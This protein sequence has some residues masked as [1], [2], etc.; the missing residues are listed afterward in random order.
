VT[1]FVPSPSELGEHPNADHV[2]Q[3]ARSRC[4][5]ESRGA[6]GC[7]S[8]HDPHELPSPAQR[9]AYYR[10]RCLTCHADRGC[11]LPADQ[12]RVRGVEDDCIACHMPRAPTSDVP[13]VTTTLH[14]IPRDR[15]LAPA[16][17]TAAAWP[18]ADETD[19]VPFHRDQMSPA[20]LEAT[21]RDLGVALRHRGP[22]G[23]A[24]AVPLLEK[25]LKDHPDDLL[26][27]ESL[28][29]ALAAVGRTAKGFEAFQAVLESEPNRESSLEA[30]ALLAGQHGQVD[31][32]IGLWR[33]ALA[34]DPWRSSFHGEL[35]FELNRVE[36]W[37]EA[38]ESA[39]RALR[40]N[41]ASHHARAALVLSL[42]R[43][44][45]QPEARAEFQTLLEFD[46]AD[47]EALVRWFGTLR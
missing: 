38:S 43:L 29:F 30:A 15:N 28:G 4:F 31:Q 45:R 40:I 33:R 37:Q 41:P 34:V 35:A 47:R 36:R 26:A 21:G 9:V 14:S 11:A 32:A 16:E 27:R 13:H 12:R 44:G 1:V 39:R 19:L 25:A 2:E 23:A 46:P 22:E 17:T 6:L 20:E 10:E 18:A 24:K 42:W 8:C 7:I 3:M 5:R